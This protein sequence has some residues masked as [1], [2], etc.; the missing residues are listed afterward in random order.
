L[1]PFFLLASHV[2]VHIIVT[3]HTIVLKTFLPQIFIA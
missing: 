3:L 1:F 2:S